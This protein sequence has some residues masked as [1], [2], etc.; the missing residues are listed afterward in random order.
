M[1]AIRSAPS[2]LTS[3]LTRCALAVLC[4]LALSG[5]VPAGPLPGDG[6]DDYRITLAGLRSRGVG[7]AIPV[8]ELT[9]FHRDLREQGRKLLSLG[10]ITKVLLLDW[11]EIGSFDVEPAADP[12]RVQEAVLQTDD[13][14]FQQRIT[15]LLNPIKE[16]DARARA[17]EQIAREIKRQAHEGLLERFEKS[18]RFYLANGRP[19]DRIAAA[20]LI[21]E[22]MTSE[23]KRN[24]VALPEPAPED[25]KKNVAPGTLRDLRGRLQGLYPELEKLLRDRDP[26][27]QVAAARRPECSRS[28]RPGQ[29]RGPAAKLAQPFGVGAGPACGGQGASARSCASPSGAGSPA[30]SS[31]RWG[32]CSRRP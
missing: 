15:R 2:C 5:R 1:L 3:R 6:V 31:A 32:R 8:S 19:T 10:E 21:G 20:N 26:E 23:G 27:I 11:G 25:K 13:E 14:M 17:S 24:E 4:L 18:I 16:D 30:T 9:R 28:G 22:T 12:Q 7:E 29:T